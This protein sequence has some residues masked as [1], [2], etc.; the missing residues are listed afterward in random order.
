MASWDFIKND[1]KIL[2]GEL[3]DVELHQYTGVK[4][5]NGTEVY[6]GDVIE[7]GGLVFEVYYDERDAAFMLGRESGQKH[8]LHEISKYLL[9]VIGNK[10]DW[11][12][13]V[14]LESVPTIDITEEDLNNV[15]YVIDVLHNRLLGVNSPTGLLHALDLMEG[16][17]TKLEGK[18]SKP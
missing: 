16:L 1:P 5:V 17:L 2:L 9:K 7:H 11:R 8:R 13:E 14:P 18:A 3:E 15:K 4:D 12:L 10:Y 6:E